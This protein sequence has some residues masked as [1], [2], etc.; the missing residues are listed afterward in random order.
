MRTIGSV[1]I[2]AAGT[3]TIG[4]T[5]MPRIRC[6]TVLRAKPLSAKRA[7]NSTTSTR[8]GTRPTCSQPSSL[9]N[10]PCTLSHGS[11]RWW[12]SSP[13]SVAPATIA[14][15][16][17]KAI[18]SIRKVAA[19]N[20][21]V[22]AARSTGCR[23]LFFPSKALFHALRRAAT[24]DRRSKAKL[25]RRIFRLCCQRDPLR[26]D[27][28]VHPGDCHAERVENHVG[29]RDREQAEHDLQSARAVDTSLGEEQ[30][31]ETPQ[32][33]RK[34]QALAD[35]VPA[36]GERTDS[37]CEQQRARAGQVIER[38]EVQH[39]HEVLEVQRPLA[40][41]NRELHERDQGQDDEHHFR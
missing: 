1:A 8:N 7:R 16:S 23:F 39:E 17:T 4:G 25:C 20:G 28:C 10:G 31:H 11:G 13:E 36:A 19:V 26:P 27:E 3:E 32:V 6:A 5:Q 35:R 12:C 29:H 41:I 30:I 34:L 22:S 2:K 40:S 15:P 18:S 33:H 14:K 37:C 38:L 9:S 24:R 21:H